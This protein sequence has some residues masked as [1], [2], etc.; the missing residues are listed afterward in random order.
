MPVKYILLFPS[1]LNS[2]SNLISYSPFYLEAT[3]FVTDPLKEGE[4]SCSP[5]T[6][7]ENLLSIPYELS[8]R[9]DLFLQEEIP[10]Y[11]IYLIGPTIKA[12]CRI[13][14]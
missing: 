13:Y 2:P 4:R 3:L 12:E 5:Q 11:L 9:L 6:Y 14:R 10:I 8:V 7:F 1:L